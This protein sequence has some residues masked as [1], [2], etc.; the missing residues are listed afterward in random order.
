MRKQ[1]VPQDQGIAQGLKE[2]CYAVDEQGRY[3]LVPSTG[4]EPKNIANYQAWEVIARQLREI[5]ARVEAGELSP[6][7]YH[8]AKNQMDV[9]LLAQYVELPRW[10]VKRHLKP[11]VFKKLKMELLERYARLFGISPA[12]LRDPATMH[13]ADLPGAEGSENAD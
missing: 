13:Q 4:W 5:R 10:R 8:M 11:K 9:A 12:Q 1:D 3:T 6:L 2:V 7:A